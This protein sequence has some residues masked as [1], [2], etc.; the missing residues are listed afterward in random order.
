MGL[1][2]KAFGDI[3]TFSRS[4][5]ATR[6]GPNG[7]VQYAPHNL[8]LQ[9]QTFDNASW[10]KTA[11]SVTANVTAAPDGTVTAEKIIESA[12]TANHGIYQ[13]ITVVANVPHTFSIYAKAVERSWLLINAYT[14]NSAL[15]Y[16]DLTNGTVGSVASGVTASIQSVGN[17][18][19]RCFVTRTPTT[20]VFE[21][22]VQ[23]STGNGISSYAGD[24]T[25]GL[26]VWGAQLSVGPLP[27]D[28]TPTT[29]AAVYGPR[30]DYDPSEVTAVEPIATNL[31]TYSEQFDNAAWT[32]T[33]ATVTANATTSP[34]G[35]NAADTING[36]VGSAYILQSLSVT[37]GVTYTFSVYA[38]ANTTN[39][40]QLAG[41][42]SGFGANVW[43]NFD[44]S[45]GTVGA[46]GSLTTA[47]IQSVGSGWY[48]CVITGAATASISPGN[49]FSLIPVESSSA[50]RFPTNA[51]TTSIYVWGAQFEL[52][53]KASAYMV[54][55]A[56]N[57]FRATPTTTGNVPARGLL[58]E[59]QRTNLFTYSEDYSN[60]A[61]A[62]TTCTVTA[63]Q[64][65]APDGLLTADLIQL[66]A[67][68]TSKTL[69]ATVTTT[70]PATMSVYA[71][72]GSHTILQFLNSGTANHFCNFDL[73][74][75]VLGNVG[76][77]TV[78]TITP[79]GNGWYRCTATFSGTMGTGFWVV[80]ANAAA[81]GY[82]AT[83]SSTGFYFLWGA[84]L[85]AGSF[86]TSY[87]PTVASSVTRSADV[88]TINTL[89]PFFN[90]T[91]GTMFAQFDSAAS[92]TNTIAAFDDNTANENYRLRN[93]GTDPK[94]TVTDGGVDQ[95]DIN[96]GT[97]AA[98]TVYNFAAAYKANDFAVC[99]AGGTVQTDTSGT[100]PTVDRLRIGTS[101]AGNYLNGHVRRFA[102]Y[103]RRLANAEL[104]ALTA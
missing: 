18:W 37:S 23:T 89:S 51:G 67:G 72:A 63:N 6:I 49:I 75:G 53:S 50:T 103:P 81:N 98:N 76:S 70:S 38:K 24:G 32:K 102:Y 2:Q 26:F 31:L 41:G 36:S 97:I 47:S 79:V 8:I 104:Q 85:E 78:G 45:G 11:I 44:L 101:Q 94:F 56:T 27:L 4:S 30:F 60:A 86:A 17:G 87:I 13:N 9:S 25:S 14:T 22:N 42:S 34:N 77:S 68:T 100:L 92:G 46:T 52:G 59:E 20:T 69:V 33:S 12:T 74:T 96:G 16:F 54:S 28:Y 40:L 82:N 39:F 19:Y 15:V 61:W 7:L 93:V 73:G 84:Q 58:I 1:I 88:A 48:R 57:G 35:T 55:G 3:I 91:E 80:A 10:T 99:I 71:K 65:V 90:A 95:C 43:A 64:L 62:K 5:N 66:G 29:T 83:T 21:P